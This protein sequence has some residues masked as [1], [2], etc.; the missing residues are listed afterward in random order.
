MEMVQI[1]LHIN[2]RLDTE[3]HVCDII[4]AINNL[5]I[6]R[7]WSCISQIISGLEGDLT[8]LTESQKEIVR[9]FLEKKLELFQPS[10]KS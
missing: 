3:V 7:R 10:K 4:A 2:R 1:E 5:E 9:T 6:P 8:D